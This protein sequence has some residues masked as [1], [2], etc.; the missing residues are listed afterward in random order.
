[1]EF[2]DQW[3]SIIVPSVDKENN[4]RR[5]VLY[6]LK[7]L[8]VFRRDVKK[9]RVATVQSRRYQ[10]SNSLFTGAFETTN[11]GYIVKVVIRRT[12]DGSNM[13]YH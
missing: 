2:F 11:S 6:L 8:D 4:A 5:S 10:C 12:G 7:F 1:M 9:H 3:R 13:R